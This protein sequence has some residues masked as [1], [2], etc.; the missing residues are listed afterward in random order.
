MFA[1]FC[2]F[3]AKKFRCRNEVSG[4]SYAYSEKGWIN[5]ELFFYFWEKHFLVHAVARRPL[6]LLLDGHNTHSDMMSLKFARDHNVMIIC[7]PP[8]TTH[9]CQP[10]D[11]SLFKLLKDRWRQE[12][13]R[14]YCN[15]PR[16][17]ISKLNFNFVLHSGWLNAGIR[18]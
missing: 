5:Y 18:I 16:T 8:H 4:T 2:N 10:L 6:L 7:L 11:C 9:K 3:A 13:H 15:H 1:S 17:V 14:F 12:C